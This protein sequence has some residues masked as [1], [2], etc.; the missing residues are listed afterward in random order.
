VAAAV[1]AA[2]MGG[3]V[4][5]PAGAQAADVFDFLRPTVVLTPAD[6]AR[7]GRGEVIVRVLPGTDGQIAVFAASVLN[8]TPTRVIERMRR[9]EELKTSRFVPVVRRFSNPPSL[10]DLA[11]L[12]L[13][14]SEINDLRRC[15]PGACGI[16]LSAAEMA[17]IARVATAENWRIAVLSAFREVV[18]QRAVTFVEHGFD[19]LPSYE[20]HGRPVLPAAVHDAILRRSPNLGDSPGGSDESFL[21]WAQEQAAGKPTITVSHVT[22][23]Q[24]E[25]DGMPAAMVTSRQVY[26]SHYM[27]GALGVTAAVRSADGTRT[28][29]VYLNRTQI[30]VLGGLFGALKRGIVEGRIGRETAGVFTEVRRRIERD[31]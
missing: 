9:I 21:Y 31:P 24:D 4:T 22:L 27:N 16:K 1:I 2:V 20:D 29:L 18:F 13:A 6:R 15:R 11:D 26:A 19:G 12:R 7:L 30:D 25:G 3:R 23:R 8:A 14:D 28:F 17:A 5:P 10:D